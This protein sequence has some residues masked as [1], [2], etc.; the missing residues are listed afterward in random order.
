MVYA[1]EAY[2]KSHTVYATRAQAE[3]KK[4][5]AISFR[6]PPHRRVIFAYDDA[7][8]PSP[9]RRFTPTPSKAIEIMQTFNDKGDRRQEFAAIA[10]TIYRILLCR[11]EDLTVIIAVQDID[12]DLILRKKMT[13]LRLER[14]I[15]LNGV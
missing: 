9:M 13:R 8:L 1:E 7:S 5:E 14:K 10:K 11:K 3:D 4:E 15:V 2:Q 6:D 12:L